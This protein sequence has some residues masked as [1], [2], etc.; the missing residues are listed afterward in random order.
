MADVHNG[1]VEGLR[2]NG[3]KVGVFNLHERLAFYELA[4]MEKDGEYVKALTRDQAVQ[5]AQNGL[6]SACYQMW[7]DV[8]LVVSG[9]FIAP[10]V[11][12]MIRARGTKVV[13]LHTESPY[14]DDR[15]LI[16]AAH[17]D[18]NLLNDPT[19][20]DRFTA[21]APTVYQ[22][23]CY[24][25]SIHRPQQVSAEYRSDFA[26]IGT[27][28]DSRISFFSEVDFTGID[29]A[30]AGNWQTLAEDSP[31]RK[32]LA[33]DIRDCTDNE[34]A[35]R[36]YAGS[37]VGANLYRLEANR[38][39]LSAGWAMGPREVE[40]AAA[41]IFFLRDPRGEG[42]EVLPMLPTFTGPEDFGELLR[43]YLSHD[44]E[45]TALAG[46]ARSAVADRT[47]TNAAASLLP[48]LAA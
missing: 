10:E 3:A 16:L 24:R 43:H 41:G 45:R 26:F 31:L 4:C 18:L 47:F 22:P 19:N 20:L 42:D 28:Y 23:H 36:L 13:L 17:A 35:A 9:F 11:L 30:L 44:T 39:E 37:K 33:H 6:L 21:V 7:P 32:H 8:L 34:E 1:W 38:P 48:R 27:G 12:D 40:M 14:E 46:Q 15:Q 25:P 2:A 5:L 29:V